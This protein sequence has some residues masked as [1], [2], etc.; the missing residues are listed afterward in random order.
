MVYA[1]LFTTQTMTKAKYDE[2]IARLS[3]W[4]PAAPP[5]RMVSF[6]TPVW[7]EDGKL[8]VLDV[9][10]SLEK[11]QAFGGILVPILA[12]I[13]IEPG[14]PHISEVHNDAVK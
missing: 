13:G 1:V 10:E 14:E 7:R 6:T 12:E 9:W 8:R 5:G 3:R 11:F 2:A 4:A